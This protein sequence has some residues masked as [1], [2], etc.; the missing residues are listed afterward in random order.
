MKPY[1]RPTPIWKRR[2][3]FMRRLPK[4]YL[5]TTCIQQ[6]RRIYAVENI[7]ITLTNREKEGNS[8]KTNMHITM[9]INGGKMRVY[10]RSIKSKGR[11][12]LYKYAMRKPERMKKNATPSFPLKKKKET[13]C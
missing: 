11:G 6:K 4:L 3:P 9:V 12:R 5:C 8:L 7:I 10:L 1:H 2:K 13:A